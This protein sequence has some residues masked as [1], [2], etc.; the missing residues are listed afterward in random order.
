MDAY[1]PSMERLIE[2][3]GELP[4]IGRRT[5]ERLAFHLLT[6]DRAEVDALAEALRDLR[7]KVTRCQECGA[8][9]EGEQCPICANPRRDRSRLCVVEKPKDVIH[10]EATGG[11][12]G[13]YHVLGGLLAPMEGEGPEKLDL[14]RLRKRAAG[15]E[16]QEV[17]LA[18]SPTAE[19]DGTALYV[20]E[21][22]Q[23][24]GVRVTRIARG[25]A[26]GSSLDYA[27]QGMLADALRGRREIGS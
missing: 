16:V 9:A 1:T 3:L 5:A 26:T 24:T 19:G 13:L 6:T 21:Q 7:T 12:N 23:G 15:G 2:A 4:G 17:I 20:A 10:I 11:Y 14:E 27:N 18:L 8:L 25:L 22:L